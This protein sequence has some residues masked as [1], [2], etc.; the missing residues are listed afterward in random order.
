MWLFMRG[1]SSGIIFNGTGPQIVKHSTLASKME[2]MPMSTSKDDECA[3]RETTETL[4]QNTL[5]RA[6]SF[7]R[8]KQISWQKEKKKNPPNGKKKPKRK[9]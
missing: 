2:T 6:S 7:L 8:Y 3:V 9:K 1:Y 5:S 4:N